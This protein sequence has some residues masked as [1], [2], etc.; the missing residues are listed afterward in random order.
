MVVLKLIEERTIDKRWMGINSRAF[1]EYI[2]RVDELLNYDFSWSKFKDKFCY[3]YDNY[4]NNTY[5]YL[6]DVRAH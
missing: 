1:F 6:L 3:L 5:R 2:K 4:R